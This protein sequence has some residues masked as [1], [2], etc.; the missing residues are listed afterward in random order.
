MENERQP[1]ISRIDRGNLIRHM[2]NIAIFTGLYRGKYYREGVVQHRLPK[3][4]RIYQNLLSN[5]YDPIK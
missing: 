4:G 3:K 5:S 2:A 1:K